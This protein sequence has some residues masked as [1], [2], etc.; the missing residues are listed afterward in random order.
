[1]S[2]EKN[3]RDAGMRYYVGDP[4]YVIDDARWSGITFCKD[5]IPRIV[6]G[7]DFE[8]LEPK[9]FCSALYHQHWLDNGRQKTEGR[10]DA[11]QVKWE[12]GGETFTVEVH[13]SPGG[14]A[15]WVFPGLTDDL[16]RRVSLGVDA[17]LLAIVPLG[18]CSRVTNPEDYGAIFKHRPSL[19]SWVNGDYLVEINGVMNDDGCFECEECGR[20]VP[21]YDMM[22][23]GIGP[24]CYEEDEDDE[25]GDYE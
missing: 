18:A 8:G 15:T 21:M 25:W 7:G 11:V 9:D 5:Y 2:D 16:G 24:C 20:R 6:P 1:M 14:D 12:E 19:E 22:D 17:G 4:C 3:L 10:M 23:D 13:D